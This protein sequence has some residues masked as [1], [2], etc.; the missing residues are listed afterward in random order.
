MSWQREQESSYR[1][2]KSIL[3]VARR[4]LLL[5]PPYILPLLYQ[6]MRNPPAGIWKGCLM[7]VTFSQPALEDPVL[8]RAR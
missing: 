7:T 3:T 4:L 5:S 6:R 1:S 2:S 8:Q